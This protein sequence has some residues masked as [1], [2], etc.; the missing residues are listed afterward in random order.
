VLRNTGTNHLM[1]I[2]GLHI[3]IMAG[4]AHAVVSYAWRFAPALLL[5]MPAQIAGACAALFMAVIYSLLA[6]FSIPTQRA[7]IMLAAFICALLSRRK[8]NAWHAWAL[9]LLIVLLVNPLS[10]LTDSF[11]LSFGTIAL[12]IYGMSGRLAP[13][14]HW[15]KWGRVQW[16]IG[17]GLMP[18]SLLLYQQTSLVSFLANSIAIP[19]LGFLILPFCFLSAILL[20]IA[21][22]MAALSLYFADK[23]L[24]V[25]WF[26]L[27]WFSQLNF[28]VWMQVI[29]NNFVLFTTVV[30]FLLLLLPSGMPGRWL[31][32]FWLL[33]LLLYQSEKPK[34]GEIWATVLDVGQGLSVVVQTHSHML[35]YD[36]GPK[37]NGVD[38]GEN[39][40]LPY[41]RT[42]LTKKIDMLVISH[43]DNDHIGGGCADKS[44]TNHSY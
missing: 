21:P 1:A 14:G 16:V 20:L 33:P 35:V 25:L 41:L 42:L 9:A 15:W 4:I 34:I 18:L 37:M 26:V 43:G 23:S 32:V 36:A 2:A 31:G 28:A 38:A 8:I 39:I 11:W 10:I 44:D 6:G 29:P 27:T 30:A 24:A 22:N 13:K 7:C 5:R 19:W 40:V 3:G 17:V 12:I